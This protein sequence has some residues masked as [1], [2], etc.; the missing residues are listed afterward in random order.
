M[1]FKYLDSK[2]LGGSSSD[3]L[4]TQG[5]A[6][7]NGIE[8]GVSY[9]GGGGGGVGAVG[10]NAS[11]AY[12]GSGGDGIENTI[13]GSTYGQ[14][15]G[16]KYW[17]G[18]GGKAGV[19][20]GNYGNY[21]HGYLFGGGGNGGFQQSAGS[22]GL[23]GGVV[24]KL[25]TSASFTT[26]GSPAVD[27]TSATNY[28]IL[29]YTSTSASSLVINSGT[30]DVQYIIQAG[31][32]GAGGNSGHG[33]GN[34]SGGGGAGG[35][36]TG[37]LSLSAGTYTVSV[38]A[39]GAGGTNSGTVGVIGSDSVFSTLTAL[40]G[41]GGAPNVG[42]TIQATSGGCGGGGAGLTNQIK[43]AS[44]TS[45]DGKPTS[46]Q[47]ID[48]KQGFDGGNGTPS[49]SG[50]SGGGGGGSAGDG[51]DYGSSGTSSDGGAGTNSS[52]A[53]S[54][55]CYAGGG[56][57]STAYAGGSGQ[58]KCGGG[59][60]GTSSAVGGNGA[61][62]SGGGGGGTDAG[63]YQ[64][65]GAGGSGVVI[66][67]Y[68]TADGS[69]STSGSV[70][71]DTST[72]S[73]QTI[74]TYTGAGTF[75][76]TST[77][78]VQYLVVAGGG[79]GGNRQHGGGGGAGGFSTSTS[80]QVTAQSYSITVGL[81]GASTSGT[82]NTA[83]SNGSYSSFG[84]IR[85]IGGGA[86]GSYDNNGGDGGSGGGSGGS[87][88]TK[89][90]GSGTTT[91]K[92][93]SIQN[94]FIMVESDTAKKFWFG[95][96]DFNLSKLLGYYKF[97]EAS[98]NFANEGL[99]D[100][101]WASLTAQN[102][103]V[104]RQ[105]GKIDYCIDTNG[106]NNAYTISPSFDWSNND[107]SVSAW[108]QM[109]AGVSNS[110]RGFFSTRQSGGAWLTLGTNNNGKIACEQNGGAYN[111]TDSSV[112]AA[113]SGW[114]HVVFTYDATANESNFYVNN[115]LVKTFTQTSIGTS[116]QYASCIWLVGQSN[117]SWIGEIDELSI[118]NEVLTASKVST[119]YNSGN[120]Q[121]L[122]TAKATSI[123][124]RSNFPTF[125]PS[126]FMAGGTNSPWTPVNFHD[127]FN[128]TTWDTASNLPT[129]VSLNAGAGTKTDGAIFGGDTSGTSTPVN[130]NQY[131]LGSAWESGT[132]MNTT[133]NQTTGGG[134]GS[135]SGWVA[136]GRV[137]S[138]GSPVNTTEQW[139]GR[140]WSTGGN[141]SGVRRN[142]AGAGIV[143][144]A[145]IVGGY[146]G[147]AKLDTMELYNG[148]V[149]SAGSNMH[150][151][152]D[153]LSQGGGDSYNCFYVG[154]NELVIGTMDHTHIYNGTSWSLGNPLTYTQKYSATMGTPQGAI[155][156]C[157]FQPN[158][159]GWAGVNTAI[160]NGTVWSSLT[161]VT[162]G[163]GTGA[164]GT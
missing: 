84:T 80:Y 72:V 154:G 83:G 98:G 38:G 81:G 132:V 161:N 86:G 125:T 7:G 6:G 90:G 47:V 23:S 15:I 157:G 30:V 105:T 143:T 95:A 27:T 33:G 77:F 35:A 13:V 50:G 42:T 112:T 57:G 120:A 155:T 158:G 89:V 117:A 79:S 104:Y 108:V 71:S 2:R 141:M 97:E 91:Y 16:S 58:G 130:K 64:T 140:T 36:L 55:V 28:T 118:W 126:Y 109:D 124:T 61:R 67:R 9:G 11:A 48:Y 37:T 85:S 163:R 102:S 18:G 151:K 62:G 43:G 122:E 73:G 59:N 19:Y 4:S 40:G 32:G 24:L 162:R 149:W 45:T 39:G 66:I 26:S 20:G 128:G 121:A 160:Y 156:A 139:N 107:W 103:P 129:A 150:D 5:F 142:S 146:T 115:V 63:N 76:P 46:T 152:T 53:G 116:S 101:D 99:G 21:A 49:S 148:S 88:A 82:G 164:G 14:N 133:R 3:F 111:L 127:Q 144:E 54:S 29:T 145:W 31:G 159:A 153:G 41:G 136:G 114:N 93:Q 119:I 92:T 25:L 106:N 70:T 100:V 69:P 12:G 68:T 135:T 22:N 8:A 94:N 113:G 75:V 137:T 52:I 56:G 87:G 51:I 17:H 74:L 96:A 65:S 110:Y 138:S 10:G 147:S 60:A 134:E 34:G 44:A 1:T 123:W 131:W 78:T